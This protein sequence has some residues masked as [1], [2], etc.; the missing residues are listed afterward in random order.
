[1]RTFIFII[2]NIFILNAYGSNCYQSLNRFI[3]KVYDKDINLD[4]MDLNMQFYQ[5]Y[6]REKS[7]QE[8][9][10][11]NSSMLNELNNLPYNPKRE[12]SAN[13]IEELFQVVKG[14]N[15]IKKSCAAV[16]EYDPHNQ[17]GFCFG[18][19]MFSHL[20]ALKFKID[21][22]LILKF[23]LVGEFENAHW[24]HH[25]AVG[26][27]GNDKKWYIVDPLFDQIFLA[28]HYLEIFNSKF[29]NRLALVPSSPKRFLSAK[30]IKDDNYAG[31][32]KRHLYHDFS[33]LQ[34]YW[35]EFFT[36]LLEELRAKQ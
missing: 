4:K 7:D 36:D 20:E 30:A 18:R 9:S 15:V 12:I 34:I 28:E 24:N 29:G 35:K 17:V 13:E 25:V 22:E 1:M 16:N 26:V 6:V 8:I 14:K 31:Y 5:K 23:W 3:S 2:L 10:A 19:A 27:R 32:Q 11:L 33:S 21:K